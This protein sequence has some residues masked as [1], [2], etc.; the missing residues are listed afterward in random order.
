M[1]T[2][3]VTGGAGYIGSHTVLALLEKG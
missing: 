2:I 3:L 1:K